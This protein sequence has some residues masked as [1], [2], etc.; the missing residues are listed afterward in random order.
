MNALSGALMSGSV[1]VFI[2]QRHVSG[3]VN[4]DHMC[5]GYFVVLL[6]GSFLSSGFGSSVAHAVRVSQP[7][8]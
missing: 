1:T 7:R 5:E 2:G 6:C 8:V 4:G 3:V